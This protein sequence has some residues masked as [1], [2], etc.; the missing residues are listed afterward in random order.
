[1]HRCMMHIAQIYDPVMY[2]CCIYDAVLFGDGRTDEQGDSRS[3]IHVTT[4]HICMMH[5][6]M[7]LEPDAC[8]YDAYIY[9]PQSLMHDA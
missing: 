6:S 2:I 7:I 9:V 8:I 4:M 5:L 3:L 1:M